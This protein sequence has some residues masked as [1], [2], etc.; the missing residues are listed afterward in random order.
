LPPL[1]Q[2]RH[3]PAG[4]PILDRDGLLSRPVGR[5]VHHLLGI[6]LHAA[7][8]NFNG[9]PT[10]ENN[11]VGFRV[12]EVP[13]PVSMALLALLALSLPKRGGLAALRR[14]R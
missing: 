7:G 12:S 10:N 1:P 11:V 13:E 2:Q 5:V 3:P 8:R 4:V 6:D 14:W 9:Y